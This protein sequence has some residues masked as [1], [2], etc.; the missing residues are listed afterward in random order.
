MNVADVANFATLARL[1]LAGRLV[2]MDA[3]LQPFPTGSSISRENGG[4]GSRTRVSAR[5]ETPLSRG[6]ERGG[7]K[8]V[9]RPTCEHVWRPLGSPVRRMDGFGFHY[10]LVQ[11]YCE[12]CRKTE[13]ASVE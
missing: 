2:R 12:R 10:R 1:P 5:P 8:G 3:V 9:N 11:W 13:W 6:N 4:G 7:S